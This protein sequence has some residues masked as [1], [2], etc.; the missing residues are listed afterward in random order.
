MCDK[1]TVIVKGRFARQV[2][3]VS[4]RPTGLFIATQLNSTSSWVELCRYKRA[5][6]FV[7]LT[8]DSW[9]EA[10]QYMMI[11]R[12]NSVEERFVIF[13]KLFVRVVWVEYLRRLHLLINLQTGQRWIWLLQRCKSGT[14]KKLSCCREAARCFMSLKILLSHSTS[15]KV[16]ENGTIQKLGTVSYWH[17]IATMAVSLA[18][19]T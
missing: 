1:I 17:S 15:F 16:I 8:F 13:I 7:S 3:T 2:E 10:M 14:H 6:K 11:V 12:Y 9:Q 19:W 4:S 5:F 18:V